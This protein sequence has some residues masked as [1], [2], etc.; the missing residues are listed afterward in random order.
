MVV[1]VE[2]LLLFQDYHPVAPVARET[3]YLGDLG[4]RAVAALVKRALVEETIRIDL[5][6]VVLVMGQMGM[7]PVGMALEEITRQPTQEW[8]NH[9]EWQCLHHLLELHLETPM[10]VGK[11]PKE[12]IL[13]CRL[14]QE[15]QQQHLS[16]E[17]VETTT[18][19]DVLVKRNAP[20]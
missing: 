10:E 7:V 20:S 13:L 5:D 18:G 9:D 2:V 3:K 12:E 6:L 19:K 4:I 8:V 14:L 16:R 17:V 15:W 1:F 11:L